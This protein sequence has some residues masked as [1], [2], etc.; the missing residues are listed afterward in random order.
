M[1]ILVKKKKIWL[2]SKLLE[3]LFFGQSFQNVD[4]GQNKKNVD[5]SKIFRTMSIWVFDKIDL[6]QNFPQILILVKI[7]EK[8]RFGSK[9]TNM[10][11]LV[12]NFKKSWFWSKF[13]K[14]SILVEIV[15]KSQ[16]RSNLSKKN[17]DFGQI[18]SKFSIWV[19]VYKKVDW[20]KI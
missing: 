18:C 17:L 2:W 7:S 8:C 12:K 11:I 14:I 3:I 20:V 19:K 6:R 9:F 16:I 4:F 13:L 10:S 15:E 5:Y 1:S